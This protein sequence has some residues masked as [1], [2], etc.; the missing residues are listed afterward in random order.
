MGKGLHKVFSTIVKNI[1]QEL[2]NFGESGS[3]VSHFI[4]E[5]RNFAEVTKLSEN[6]RKPWLKA[7]LKEIKNLINNKNFMIEDPKDGEP[8]TPC[9]DVYKAK[10]QSYGSL[11]KLKLR[12]VVRGDF[13]NKEMVG[14]TW[15]PTASMRALKYFPV[16]AEKHKAIV[17]QLD[18]IGAFL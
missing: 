18:F 12:I 14:Y 5:P 15:S 10:I 8:V 9:M 7:T 3:E 17:H 11:D 6:I 13:Q 1:S 16:D 2:T 4:P